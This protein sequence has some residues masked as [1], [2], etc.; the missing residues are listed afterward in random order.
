LLGRSAPRPPPGPAPTVRDRSYTWTVRMR[1]VQQCIWFP[2][3]SGPPL[4]QPKV[5][6]NDVL[7]QVHAAGVNLLDAGGSSQY[8]DHPTP[9]RGRNQLALVCEVNHLCI[10]L[11]CARKAKR[12]NVAFSF[13]FMRAN[14]DQLS[15]ITSLIER[16]IIRPR[17]GLGI[18]LR[19]EPAHCRLRPKRPRQGQSRRQIEM[20]CES[21][22]R[23][24]REG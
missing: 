2:S 3:P 1:L 14:G 19:R 21:P 8:P 22:D 7:V 4:P 12:F 6:G 9:N 15:E 17:D 11:R 13:L 23:T 18:S 16:G 10:E 5:G 24:G 20:R